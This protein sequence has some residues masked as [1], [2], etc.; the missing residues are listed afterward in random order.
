MGRGW[1][2]RGGGSHLGYNTGYKKWNWAGN[3]KAVWGIPAHIFSACKIVEERVGV[4]KVECLNSKT[5]VL[6]IVIGTSC[7]GH[8]QITPTTLWDTKKGTIWCTV[9]WA[10]EGLGSRGQWAPIYLWEEGNIC[11]LNLLQ[12]KPVTSLSCIFVSNDF[13]FLLSIPPTLCCLS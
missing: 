13:K 3:E 10:I 9:E 7:T 5:D 6:N 4:I 11:N 1:G 2:V 8:Q 12:N